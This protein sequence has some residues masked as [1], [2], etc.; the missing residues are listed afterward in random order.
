ME[1][2]INL[3]SGHVGLLMLLIGVAFIAFIIVRTDLFKGKTL[4]PKTGEIEN[5]GK[6]MIEG[7]FD[8][9]NQAKNVKNL[10][11]QNSRKAAE[12]Q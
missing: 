12:Q 5:D 10:V 4:N 3:K 2:K 7:G 9:I 11:E 6:N 8:A 1:N